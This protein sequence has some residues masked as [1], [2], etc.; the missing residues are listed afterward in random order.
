MINP[1][2]RKLDSDQ[3]LMEGDGS[4]KYYKFGNGAVIDIDVAFYM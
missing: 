2:N 1:W 3:I 4:H